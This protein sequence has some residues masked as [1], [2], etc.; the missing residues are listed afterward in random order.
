MKRVLAPILAFACAG[1]LATAVAAEPA[2]EVSLSYFGPAGDQHIFVSDQPVTWD[3]RKVSFWMFLGAGS[4]LTEANGA[5]YV[6]A[7]VNPVIDCTQKT[8]QTREVGT[9]TPALAVD[10]RIMGDGTSLPID[11]A[12]PVERLRALYCDG[13][14][15]GGP[16]VR[17]ENLAA[18]V[19]MAQAG[20]PPR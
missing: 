1:T 20:G 2:K 18:A 6:G 12:K 4:V 14:P 19:R 3:G 15:L 16:A 7:W 13:K 10:R 9:V 11:P 8:S 5:T 17:V